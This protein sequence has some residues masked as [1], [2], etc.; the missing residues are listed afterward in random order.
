MAEVVRPLRYAS[1]AT[2]PL[3][4]I[5]HE[6]GTSQARRT[7]STVV[8]LR[9]SSTGLLGSTSRSA[10]C[11]SV[12][13]R[14]Q[15][16]PLRRSHTPRSRPGS[17]NLRLSQISPYHRRTIED[18]LST[19]CLRTEDP[20]LDPGTKQALPACRRRRS[21]TPLLGGSLQC[22]VSAATDLPIL[23]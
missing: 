11:R 15:F 5:A 12:R 22:R 23:A 13:S 21:A 8:E 20:P 6:R 16:K 7:A 4:R 18:R 9:L 14:E 19:G 3:E 10:S 17:L 1:S 2:A